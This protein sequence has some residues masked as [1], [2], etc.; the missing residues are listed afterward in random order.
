MTNQE[1][2]E[3]CKD[4]IAT[5]QENLKQLKQ[6]QVKQEQEAKLGD[7]VD[8][9]WGKRVALFDRAGCLRLYDEHG[10]CVGLANRST[11][12]KHTGKSIFTDNLL[13]L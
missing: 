9:T 11:F 4:D 10:G 1:R 2:I 7:I 8:C 5:L 3:Q 6:E 13:G 12:Y